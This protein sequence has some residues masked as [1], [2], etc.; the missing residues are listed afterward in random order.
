MKM[1]TL[2]D[3]HK[4]SKTFKLQD[5]IKCQK[6]HSAL[7]GL[8]LAYL[9][10]HVLGMSIKLIRNCTTKETILFLFQNVNQ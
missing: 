9:S 5:N 10:V 4:S 6:I 7:S 3:C 2:N 1:K 8:D